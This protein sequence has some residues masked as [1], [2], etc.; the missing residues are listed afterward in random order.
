[1]RDELFDGD[2]V[3]EVIDDLIKQKPKKKWFRLWDYT[4]TVLYLVLYV[5]I[6]AFTL[7]C[8]F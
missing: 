8:I 6:I 3:K 1:M 7:F 5:G 4:L 2:F